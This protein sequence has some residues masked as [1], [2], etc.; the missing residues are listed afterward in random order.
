MLPVLLVL[1]ISHV[2]QGQVVLSLSLLAPV[3]PPPWRLCRAQGKALMAGAE[4][5]AGAH[6]CLEEA[7][8]SSWQRQAAGGGEG[9]LVA[10]Q[11]PALTTEAES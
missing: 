2:H 9:A 4:P 11:Q 3:Q 6:R 8:V 10:G 5:W 7:A 1:H